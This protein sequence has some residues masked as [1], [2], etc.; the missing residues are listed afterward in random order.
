MTSLRKLKLGTR[1]ALG[2]LIVT[3]PAIV[4]AALAVSGLRQINSHFLEYQELSNDSNLAGDIQAHFQW[5]LGEGLN[6]TMHQ[7]KEPLDAVN[8]NKAQVQRLLEEAGQAIQNPKRVELLATIRKEFSK[9]SNEWDATLA[10][11]QSG[12]AQLVEEST[13]NREQIGRAISDLLEEFKNSIIA[14]QTAVGLT[15]QAELREFLVKITAV[16]IGAVLLMLVIMVG[17]IRGITRVIRQLVEELIENAEQTRMSASQL[18]QTSHIL[19]EGASRQA[20]SLEETSASVEEMSGMT[21]RNAESAVSAK[22]MTEESK[23][24]V[25][26]GLSQIRKLRTA[27]EEI[28]SAVNEM[29]RAV[30]ETRTAGGEMVKIVRT[31]DEIAF[32]TNILA[33]NAAVEAARAGEAGAGFAVVAEEV[34]NLAQRSASA[35]RE[36]TEKIEETIRRSE[37][38]ALLNEKLGDSLGRVNQMSDQ[39]QSVFENITARMQ[40]LSHTIAQIALASQEQSVGISQINEAVL[41]MDTLTQSNAAASEETASAATELAGQADLLKTAVGE[42]KLLVDGP[43]KTPARRSSQGLKSPGAPHT[44]S[45]STPLP[46]SRGHSKPAKNGFQPSKPSLTNAQDRIPL[47]GGRDSEFEDM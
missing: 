42:L 32:Q 47:P 18:E 14:D 46:E 34:R 29:T 33:L 13:H 15:N 35:A 2:F 8:E 25:E 11:I 36:T 23:S 30:L 22:D 20:T 16:S 6:Y 45:V 7:E 10:A 31:I 3:V 39:V 44:I 21:K 38:G 40:D 1:L 43:E 5:M 9:F 41:Q 4:L 12:Q 37:N 19:A 26:D 17:T 24:A 28:K 27:V